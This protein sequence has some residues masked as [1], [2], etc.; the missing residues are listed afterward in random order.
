MR[1][2]SSM[3]SDTVTTSLNEL[4]ARL[5]G[6]QTN[7]ATSKRLHK[8]SDHPSA[9]VD[10]MRVKSALERLDRFERNLGD[11]KSYLATTDSALDHLTQILQRASELAVQGANSHMP[12]EALDSL[13]DEVDKLLEGAVDVGNTTLA[14]TYL[15]A[16]LKGDAPPFTLAAGVVTYNGDNGV[17][18]REVS[19]GNQMQINLTGNDLLAASDI[20]NVL[21]NLSDR[22]RAGDVTTIS[23]TSVKEVQNALDGVLQLRSSVGARHRQVELLEARQRDTRINM[24]SQLELLEGIDMEKTL[25]EYNQVDLAYRTALAIG[26][27]ILPPSLMD[28]LR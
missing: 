3:M 19:P 22:L 15:F 1:I 24:E 4:R 16:G 21:K 12:Q 7:L 26:G 18:R 28:F 8:P 14:G 13:A 27:R 9:T 11:A 23:S 5:S 6:L 10:A 25:I 20:F 17:L 2:T